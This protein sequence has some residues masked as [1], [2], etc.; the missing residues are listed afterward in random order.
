MT[1]LHWALGIV[2]GY[3]AIGIAN[4]FMLLQTPYAENP[5]WA[6]ILLWPFYWIGR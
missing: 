3:I 6:L 2:I 4:M 5:K 1:Y